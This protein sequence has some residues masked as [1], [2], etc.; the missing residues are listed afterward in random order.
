MNH[1]LISEDL[2]RLAEIAAKHRPP[3]LDDSYLLSVPPSSPR[4]ER[5]KPSVVKEFLDIQERVRIRCMEIL[6][7]DPTNETAQQAIEQVKQY[8][9]YFVHPSQQQELRRKVGHLAYHLKMYGTPKA[10]W[11]EEISSKIRFELGPGATDAEFFAFEA[12]VRRAAISEITERRTYAEESIQGA[13]SQVRKTVPIDHLV[14]ISIPVSANETSIEATGD[15]AEAA[16]KAAKASIPVHASNI[17]SPTIIEQSQ[18][19]EF[20]VEALTEVEA[21]SRSEQKLPSG[22]QVSTID[23]LQRP[24]KGF[25]GI[26]K[27]GGIWAVTYR[28]P[29]RAKISFRSPPQVSVLFF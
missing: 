22:C 8:G 15:T 18:S 26:A 21:R 14:S 2:D 1:Y 11:P 13:L 20:K 12:E 16:I 10:T 28:T 29:F 3:W 17:G 6:L 27:R 24:K 23:C 25:L 9:G 4:Y 7:D 5:P 19:G